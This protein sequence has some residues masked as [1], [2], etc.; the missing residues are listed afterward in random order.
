M[1]TCAT[2]WPVDTSGYSAFVDELHSLLRDWRRRPASE[3]QRDR[4]RAALDGY[5]AHQ[6]RAT[7]PIATRRRAGLFFTSGF[8]ASAV[9][10]SIAASLTKESVVFDPACGAGDL[11]LAALSVLPTG[12]GSFEQS[13]IIGRDLQPEFVAAARLRLDLAELIRD[14][15]GGADYELHAGCGLCDETAVTRATHVV[16][17]PPFTSMTSPP[18]CKW[19]TGRVNTAAVFVAEIVTSARAGTIVATILPD[20]VRSGSR[21]RKWRSFVDSRAAVEQVELLG[22]FDPWTNV[23][24]LLLRLTVGTG[25]TALWQKAGVSRARIGDQFE[26]AVGPVVH[27]RDPHEGPMVA[28]LRSA[29]MPAWTT[30]RRITERRHFNGR[31]ERPPFAVVRRTSSPTEPQRA[32][33]N[34][35]LGRRPVAVDNHLIVLR[36]RDGTREACEAALRVLR[37]QRTSSWLNQR[38]RCRHLTTGVVSD[39]PWDD[40]D[41]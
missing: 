23:D 34:V 22:R 8:L 13:R 3:A 41:G 27:N 9:L 21:Y 11:L 18:D 19:A 31:L 24:T 4:V 20:V 28:Y 12:D 36:P 26:V 40:V 25:A 15:A 33:A 10:S 37:D 17:N 7:V 32:R 16:M 2:Q 35:V 6:L 29:S 14:R 1:H 5:A 38:I 39:I 30:V